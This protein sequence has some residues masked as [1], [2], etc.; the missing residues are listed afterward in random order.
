MPLPVP[1][2]ETTA[3]VTG[4]SS[5]IGADLAR[6]LAARGHGVV[7]VARRLDRLQALAEELTA[8]HGIRAEAIACDLEDPKAR[9]AL[10]AK[11]E[12]LGLTVDILVNNAGFGTSGRFDKLDGAREA[13]MVRLNCEAVVALSSAYAPQFVERGSGAILIVASSAGMQPIPKQAT[14]AASKAF[15][16]T[17]G[18]SLHAELKP[19][20]VSVTSLCP[21]PVATEF[22]E[23]AGLE[24]MFD[25]VPGFAQVTSP[26]CAAAAIEGLADNRR[27]VVPGIFTKAMTLSGRH[28]PRAILLPTLRRFYPA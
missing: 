28:T 10:P 11:I 24:D 9:D 8:A 7:L 1:S 23:T 3:L 20:G 25:S 27:V 6:E 16:H 18:E 19:Y 5:G 13:S 22:A 14:Y 21:G 26:E 4:A 15:A 17:F 2:P 12:K